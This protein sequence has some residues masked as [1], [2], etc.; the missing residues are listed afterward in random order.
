MPKL[1]NILKESISNEVWHKNLVYKKPNM[2]HNGKPFTGVAV[3]YYDEKT[4]IGDYG[5]QIHNEEDVKKNQPYSKM[6]Y[7]NGKQHGDVLG[8][9]KNGKIVSEGKFENGKGV[10]RHSFYT[11]NGKLYAYRDY[12]NGVGGEVVKVKD[13]EETVKEH[14]SPSDTPPNSDLDFGGLENLMVQAL[15]RHEGGWG[16]SPKYFLLYIT[17]GG[18]IRAIKSSTHSSPSDH[19]FKEGQQVNLSDLIEFERNS[20]FDLRMKGRIRDSRINEEKSNLHPIISYM[21]RLQPHY[22]LL[23]DYIKI[24]VYFKNQGYSEEDLKSVKRAPQWLFQLQDGFAWKVEKIKRDLKKIGLMNDI[25]G[26]ESEILMDYLKNEMKKIDLEFPM[27]SPET[28]YVPPIM[29][30]GSHFI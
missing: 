14:M 5:Q 25:Y 12:T 9:A 17:P 8:F 19:N 30:D 13:N 23:D 1:V 6:S 20:R 29:K 27:N 11:D 28:S 2:L 10:G 22:D 16:V 4:K 3:T 18:T 24:R 7:K 21:E 26:P 15:F